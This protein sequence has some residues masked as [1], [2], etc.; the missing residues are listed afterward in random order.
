MTVRLVGDAVIE[1]D[2]VCSIED[3]DVLLQHLLT[4]PLAAIDWRSCDRAHAAVVQLMLVSKAKLIGP[5]RSEFLRNFIE[6][7]LIRKSA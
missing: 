7:V 6:S 2:G 3:A 4:A 1:L 5:P